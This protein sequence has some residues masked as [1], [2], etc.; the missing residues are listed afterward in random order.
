M[1]VICTVFYIT[2]YLR[3][4]T[5]YNH[6]F[7]NYQNLSYYVVIYFITAILIY[8]NLSLY[9]IKLFQLI[10][11]YL[12]YFGYFGCVYP[13]SRKGHQISDHLDGE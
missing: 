11:G 12:T 4:I 2:G 6:I 1:S 3:F 9:A 7:P 5:K 13:R 8:E 10:T